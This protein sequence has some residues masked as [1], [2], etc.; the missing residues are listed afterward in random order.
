MFDHRLGL[1]LGRSL[2]EVRALP[3]PEWKSW[4][5]FSLVEPW[6]WWNTEEQAARVLT[7]LHNVNAK[8]AKAPKDFMRDMVRELLE[9]LKPPVNLDDL[10]EEERRRMI[11]EAVKRDFGVR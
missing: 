5:V 3:Y 11:I 8:K 6:G 7:M 2:G 4:Y 10:P 9:V 1:A